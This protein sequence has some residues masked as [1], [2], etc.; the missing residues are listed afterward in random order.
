MDLFEI[1]GVLGVFTSVLSFCDSGPIAFVCQYAM[2][3]FWGTYV[4]LA[5][6]KGSIRIRPLVLYMLAV[7]G[8]MFI[9]GNYFYSIGYYGT[10]GAG[11]AMYLPYCA[12]FYFVGYN[13]YY[14]CKREAGLFIK[15]YLYA[16]VIFVIL[17]FFTLRETN[18]A[19]SGKNLSAQIIGL[20]VVFAL[21]IFPL[22]EQKI[23]LKRSFFLF[24]MFSFA[25]LI[26]M[27]SRTPA[28]AVLITV[29]YWL[30]SQHKMKYYLV[31]FLVIAIGIYYLQ[32]EGGSIFLFEY[33]QGDKSSDELTWNVVTSGRT[34]RYS[35][36]LL[37]ILQ[38]P[39]FGQGAWGYL[40]S[41]P[42]HVLRTGGLF[43][44]FLI[45]PIAYGRMLRYVKMD[46]RRDLGT[47]ENGKDIMINSIG[48]VCVYYFGISLFEGYP[49]LGPG[50]SSFILWILI[51][52]VDRYCVEKAGDVTPAEG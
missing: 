45:F 39:F 52:I 26:L 32:T 42:L 2:Y 9:V 44:G 16:Y 19:G 21:F 36:V 29:S 47:P 30:I 33:L 20:G 31:A 7:F 13:S 22:F 14:D 40:D 3:F 1:V 10:S 35:E 34:D 28:F 49:P 38:R 24:A 43:A 46:L 50:V 15:T 4:I 48:L 5:L 41:F 18:S 12:F 25:V 51:G 17:K 27:H 11:P 8:I 6:I 37:E 23:W